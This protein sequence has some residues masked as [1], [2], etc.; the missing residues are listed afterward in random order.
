MHVL[1]SSRLQGLYYPQDIDSMSSDLWTDQPTKFTCRFHFG[2]GSGM[3]E[4]HR[5]KSSHLRCL[6]LYAS[7]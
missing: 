4:R 5:T 6:P 2:A 3:S 1:F 7:M